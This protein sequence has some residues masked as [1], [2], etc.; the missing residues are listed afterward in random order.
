MGDTEATTFLLQQGVT[1]ERRSNRSRAQLLAN[2]VEKS[3]NLKHAWDNKDFME[4]NSEV[5]SFNKKGF[6]IFH[7]PDSEGDC[8]KIMSAK[9]M[10]SVCSEK[11]L[12]RLLKYLVAR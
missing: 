7:C 9:G 2:S 8:E 11:E 4:K 6:M 3:N 12:Q 5:F 1:V 10:C